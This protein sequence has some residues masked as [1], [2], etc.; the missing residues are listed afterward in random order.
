MLWTVVLNG[1]I[2]YNSS[3]SSLLKRSFLLQRNESRSCEEFRDEKRLFLDITG[4]QMASS[5][6]K[7]NG[8]I[9]LNNCLKLRI[10]K[11]LPSL[12]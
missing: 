2:Y 10:K 6:S 12:C 4:E 7:L 9:M 3:S 1:I 8:N 5:V 11:N